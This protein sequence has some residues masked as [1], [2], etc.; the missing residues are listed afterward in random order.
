MGHESWHKKVRT[1]GHL[2]QPE[3]LMS[4]KDK[5]HEPWSKKIRFKKPDAVFI[6]A[7]EHRCSD[8]TPQERGQVHRADADDLLSTR[9]D[10][11]AGTTCTTTTRVRSPLHT[12]SHEQLQTSDGNERTPTPTRRSVT[13]NVSRRN[14]CTRA[15]T[16]TS[17]LERT[18]AQTRH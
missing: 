11:P 16:Q 2:V 7:P 12:Y 9:V 8:L 13:I 4:Q 14:E 5:G 17:A 15:Q 10:V 3:F 18:R 6:N 1:K